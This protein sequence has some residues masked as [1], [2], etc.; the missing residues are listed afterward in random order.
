M[1]YDSHVWN[2][3]IYL[4]QDF[5]DDPAW[6][7]ELMAKIYNSSPFRVYFCMSSRC[8]F[9]NPSCI[10]TSFAF[11]PWHG[12]KAIMTTNIVLIKSR[13]ILRFLELFSAWA[14]FRVV[15]QKHHF[16]DWHDID[17]FTRWSK[18]RWHDGYS[19]LSF[20]ISESTHLEVMNSWTSIIIYLAS[21]LFNFRIW[22]WTMWNGWL[23]T[24][25][26]LDS[27]KNCSSAHEHRRITLSFLA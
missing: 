13:Q 6:N 21:L 24:N 25:S 18:R 16:W 26:Q 15:L 17:R 27:H 14:I 10:G 11:T 1:E 2:I 12:P 19:T 7:P 4:L 22:I 5:W 23:F 9:S 20:Y 8:F 3:D